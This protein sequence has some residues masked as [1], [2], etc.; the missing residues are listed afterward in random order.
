VGCR[1]ALSLKHTE[2]CKLV[3]SK[4]GLQAGTWLHP[5]QH[6]H[7]Q[8]LGIAKTSL[9]DDPRGFL[10]LTLTVPASSSPSRQASPKDRA[11]TQG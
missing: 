1:T 6:S 3:S 11:N 5:L 9:D 7:V 2:P 8:D 10:L 4:L